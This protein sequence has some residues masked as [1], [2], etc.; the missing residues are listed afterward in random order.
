M[1]NNSINKDDGEVAQY[2]FHEVGS[3]PLNSLQYSASL[4]NQGTGLPALGYM[5]CTHSHQGGQV[6]LIGKPIEIKQ[7]IYSLTTTTG[8][9]TSTPFQPSL[10]RPVAA[11]PATCAAPRAM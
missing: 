1:D 2:A 10:K 11:V 5:P 8:A 7:E 4:G 9:A 6:L 3:E